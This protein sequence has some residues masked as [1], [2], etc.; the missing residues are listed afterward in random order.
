MTTQE[1]TTNEQKILNTLLEA[2]EISMEDRDIIT[3]KILEN[4]YLDEEMLH[5]HTFK[6][7]RR[8]NGFSVKIELIVDDY[9]FHQWA[10]YQEEEAF[11]RGVEI[12]ERL[13]N[14]ASENKSN[15]VKNKGR[16]IRNLFGI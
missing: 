15:E 4:D 3:G 11:T 10:S 12:F 9:L 16:N 7:R 8:L 13:A 2:N 14:R 6:L 1:L 5:F